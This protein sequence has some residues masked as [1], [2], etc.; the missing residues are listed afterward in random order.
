MWGMYSSLEIIMDIGPILHVP[1]QSVQ[2]YDIIY[3]DVIDVAFLFHY[4]ST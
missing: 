3:E 2:N 1:S 4:I